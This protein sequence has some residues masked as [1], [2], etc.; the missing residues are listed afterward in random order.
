V[1]LVAAAVCPHPPLLIPAVGVGVEVA[2]RP[3]AAAAVANLVAADPGLVVVV[4]AGP[5]AVTYTP[6]SSGSLG[7]FGVDQVVPLGPRLGGG[8]AALP[9]SITVGAW[10]LRETTW[11][12]DREAFG[13]PETLTSAE[14]AALGAE[15]AD[16]D[17]RVALLC[18]GDGS[19]R[20]SERAPGWFDSR[21]EAFDATVSTAL[22]AADPAG[23]LRLDAELARELL[24]AGRASWQV[25]GGAA[26]G[27]TWRGELTYDEAPFGVGYFV[28]TWTVER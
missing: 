22:T 14:A 24:V 13:V 5:A 1:T 3:A 2:A 12:G 17:E 7:G 15:L 21:A 16:L 20:R 25:L 26:L 28:A 23:L 10:L 27:Q 18:M 8:A 4:G 11:T 6:A 19:A 9:L